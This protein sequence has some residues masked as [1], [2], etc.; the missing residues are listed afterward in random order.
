MR[1]GKHTASPR[2]IPLK[3]RG[4]AGDEVDDDS[5]VV[6][7]HKARV[8][9]GVYQAKYVGH[10]TAILFAHAPKVFLKFEVVGESGQYDGVRLIRPYR[11]RRLIGRPG[12]N[13]KFV[14]SA[15]GDLYR[16]LAKLLDARARP[17]RISLRPLRHM[18]FRVRTRTV[19]RDRSGTRLAEAAQYSVI[20]DIEDG[21]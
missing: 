18:L 1:T 15:G 5:M 2:V 11:V 21:R 6:E 3:Q 17:D 16:M 14:L 19:D 9:D 12:P 7:G 20:A 8:R 10:D 13:G 4:D